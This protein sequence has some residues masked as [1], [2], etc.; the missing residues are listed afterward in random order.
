MLDPA[1]RSVFMGS[2][3]FEASEWFAVLVGSPSVLKTIAKARD[4]SIL[5]TQEAV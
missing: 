5:D 3:L 1:R 4:R 2:S